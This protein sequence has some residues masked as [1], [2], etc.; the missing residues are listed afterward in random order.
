[1]A[2]PGDTNSPPQVATL[3]LADGDRH[4]TTIQG[5]Q[6]AASLRLYLENDPR[7]ATVPM[8]N[9]D[10]PAWLRPGDEASIDFQGQLRIGLWLLQGRGAEA[11]L[12]YR[13]PGGGT[14]VGYQHIA[15]LRQLEGR[16]IV[17]E[18]GWE[19]IFYTR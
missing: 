11:I 1:M 13:P 7:V 18:I 6:I 17:A 8:L 12:T 19:K 5:E 3:R 2:E 9:T 4:F 10:S 16:W 14:A 15:H